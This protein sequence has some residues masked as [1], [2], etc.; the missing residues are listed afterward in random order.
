MY[1]SAYSF[2]F[3]ISFRV[4]APIRSCRANGLV[5]IYAA[6]PFFFVGAV[7][8]AVLAG[9]FAGPFLSGTFSLCAF[10][11]AMLSCRAAR[12]S[13]T[14]GASGSGVERRG[15]AF[16]EVVDQFLEP[17]VLAVGER[18]QVD[19]VLLVRLDEGFGERSLLVGDRVFDLRG[20]VLRGEVAPAVRHV[21]LAQD[22]AAVCC[23]CEGA[24]L[25]VT[26]AVVADDRDDSVLEHLVSQHHVRL[27]AEF[28]RSEDDVRPDAEPV[29]LDCR[30][31][32]LDGH[33]LGLRGFELLDL[34]GRDGD[35]AVFGAVTLDHVRARARAEHS[36]VAG[37]AHRGLLQGGVDWRTDLAGLLVDDVHPEGAF[38]VQ[39]LELDVLVLVLI[40]D[41]LH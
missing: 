34:V 4:L 19:E 9:A 29:D 25:V 8:A 31:E 7:G 26:P 15:L 10:R 30:D 2:V 11:A 24:D 27:A 37:R 1:A 22:E 33:R 28:R 38:L 17:V 20:A 41:V 35:E 18:R 40:E 13:T 39:V 3:F 23:G 21:E 12:R 16:T 36:V 14:G 5:S 6:L 32:G